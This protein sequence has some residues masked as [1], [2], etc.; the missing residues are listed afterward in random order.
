MAK[1]LE[2][3]KSKGLQKFLALSA[4]I[5]LFIFFSIFGDNFFSAT[6]FVNI[7]SQSYY[8]GFLAL[9]VTFVIITGGIDLSVG[10]VM[11]CA[12]LMG[13][14]AYNNLHWPIL[15]CLALAV[16]IGTA[17][18]VFNGLIIAKLKLPP[19]I[20]TLGT[21]LISQGLG[22]IV[23]QVQ[24]QR[25]PT[26][27]DPDGWFKQVFFK[28]ESG[29]PTGIIFLAIFFVILFIVLN[30]TKMGRYIYAIGSNEEA[31]RLSGVNT[32]K[33]KMSAYIIS[34]LFAGL[35]GIDYAA[36]Y[37]VII[38]GSG[39]GMELLA[40]AAVVIGGTSLSGGIGTLSGTLIGVYIMSVLSTG[41]MSM[42]LQGQYQTFFTGVVVILAVLLD[43]YR[44]KRAEKIKLE[45]DEDGCLENVKVKKEF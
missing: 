1:I 34:G 33:W 10:T 17:F 24:T 23:A 9:G 28:T 20:A 31:T 5:I 41:L 35:A 26:I 42:S 16:V 15:A 37:T 13:G 45:K 3:V 44:N 38:P 4:L 32:N 14:L 43:I 30:K 27:Y 39:G 7:L 11:I 29:F 21:M 25:Y 6:S 22:S 12:T 8:I 40:I 2:S 19:F 18:G 36:A